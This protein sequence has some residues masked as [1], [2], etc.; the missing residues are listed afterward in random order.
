MGLFNQ[1]IYSTTLTGVTLKHVVDSM[2]CVQD[3]PQFDGTTKPSLYY[4]G[5]ERM[6][7][8]DIKLLPGD[9]WPEE[10]FEW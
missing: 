6:C 8:Y 10:W 5:L 4:Q 2:Y 3:L 9:A 1:D 7:N